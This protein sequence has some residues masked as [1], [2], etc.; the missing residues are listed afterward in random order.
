MKHTKI[1]NLNYPYIFSS[2]RGGRKLET[3]LLKAG[4]PA[5]V[6]L[7]PFKVHKKIVGETSYLPAVS[8]EWKNSV[9]TYNSNTTKNYP[10]Y[11]LNINTLIKG[12][13][14]MYFKNKFMSAG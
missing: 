2:D 10:A 4:N 1:Q 14:N 3:S 5:A 12:Y 6:K 9:Y 8:K 13:F 11:N 7:T